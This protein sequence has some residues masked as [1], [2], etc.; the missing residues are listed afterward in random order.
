L[1][2]LA[3]HQS[4][5]FVKLLLIGDSKAGKTGSLVS[6]A[7]AGYKLRILDLDNLLDPLKYFIQ[8]ECPERMANVEYRTLRD[9]RKSGATGVVISGQPKAYIDTIKMLDR[10]KYTDDLGNE[11]DLGVPSEWGPDCILIIDSL[12]RLCDAAYDWREP[13]TPAGK[14]GERDGRAIYGDA[15]DAIENLLAMLT[16]PLMAT[17][18]I[19]IA[20]G[21]YMELGDGTS[22][23]FPQGVGQKLSPKIPQYFPSVIYYKNTA[24][25]RT[26]QLRSSPMID[27]ANPAPFAM[28]E[29]LTIETGLAEFFAVLRD[30]P[31]QETAIPPK[32]K[33]LT[34]KRA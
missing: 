5:N 3:N 11:V 1:P 17:N 13:L 22:K 26:I 34:L 6:L 10:W 25:K 19:V 9:K 20:H 2:N 14:S 29:S 32:P 28:P 27:L 33:S 12:S 7:K 4:N 18:V 15:Q 16:G 31:K 21:L 24:G 8:R 23:I 30:P